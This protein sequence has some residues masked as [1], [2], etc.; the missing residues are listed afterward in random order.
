MRSGDGGS[1]P[2]RRECR[3]WRRRCVRGRCLKRRRR[4]PPAHA[5][6]R[7]AREGQVLLPSRWEQRGPRPRSGVTAAAVP[8]GSVRPGPSRVRAPP[9]SV[10]TQCREFAR[11]SDPPPVGQRV[12]PTDSG[13]VEHALYNGARAHARWGLR[14]SS[15]L[16]ASNSSSH[17]EVP[18]SGSIST[19][20]ASII[21]DVCNVNVC[22]SNFAW[23]LLIVVCEA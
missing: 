3:A 11:L 10:S 21:Q 8:D 16:T 4:D 5:H 20:A 13:P 17:R 7:P 15:S 2:W 18:S 23:F 6:R 19:C 9:R 12:Q 14:A 22:V 1:W